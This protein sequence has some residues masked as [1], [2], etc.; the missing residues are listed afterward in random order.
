[1][2]FSFAFQFRVPQTPCSPLLILIPVDLELEDTSMECICLQ[3][4][5]KEKVK[6][7]FCYF[8]FYRS[9]YFPFSPIT[10]NLKRII[11]NYFSS[12]KKL[13][14]TGEEKNGQ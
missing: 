12:W 8:C 6:S 11:W 7:N 3:K 13:F 10:V 2:K 4:A 5:L 1:M 14:P 9:N